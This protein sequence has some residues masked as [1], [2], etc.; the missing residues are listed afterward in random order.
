MQFVEGTRHLRTGD[1][2]A[3]FVSSPTRFVM[4][5]QFVSSG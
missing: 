1:S 5:K 2:K 4:I 3:G